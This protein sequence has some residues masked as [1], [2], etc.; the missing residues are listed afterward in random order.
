ML[1]G[2]AKIN[3]SYNTKNTDKP[4]IAL[5]YDI[6]KFDIQ[7]TFTYL[8]TVQ[9]IAPLAKYLTGSFSTDMTLNS[10]L[11]NDLSLDLTMLNGL[12]K[13][14]IPYATFNELPMFNKISETLKL[15]AFDKP[16]LN[17]AW[18]ILKFENGK[19]NVEPF[20]IKMKDIVMDIE[21]SN[22]FD[23]SIDYVVKLSVPSDKFGGAA[24]LAN[25]FLSKQKIPLLNL[26]VPQI[27]HFHL[28][29]SGAMTSPNVKIVKVSAGDSDKGVK[30]QI[31]E[32][33]KEQLD[34]AKQDIANKAQ[35]EAD[36]AKAQA[37]AEAEKAK[38]KAQEEAEKAKQKAQEEIEKA[39]EDLK[40]DIK[41]KIKG[42]KW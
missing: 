28:N 9:A 21:G 2:S 20:Q 23:Q 13:V 37:Q 35:E 33:L 27:L 7:K 15:P 12:G 18:T 4:E 40:E 22:S 19:V 30:E 11:N 26:S 41:D 34:Q 32:D 39:K 42:F 8:N 29:V 3:G 24:S 31:K 14:T 5:S 17:N 10:F 16:A 36:K 25:D 1:G 38:Q 6:Q